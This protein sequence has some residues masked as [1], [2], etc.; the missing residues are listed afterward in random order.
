MYDHF[1]G[2]VV[3]TSGTRVVLRCGGVGYELKVPVGTATALRPGQ[4]ATLHT[5]LHVVDGSPSLI[6]FGSPAERDLA[7]RILAVSGVGPAIAL[8]ILSTYDPASFGRTILDGDV[9]ALKRVKGVGGKTA[10]RL[11]LE[12]R[13][14][15][16]QL[17]LPG[18]APTPA[19]DA[20]TP[21]ASDA[22]AALVTLGYVEKDASARV[23]KA[24]DADPD[25]GTEVLIRAVLRTG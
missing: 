13:D 9:A 3:E 12:L 23:A 24:L 11:C 4:Q 20:A 1:L 15:I 10:E 17:D 7:R 14:K 6:G 19:Q 2:E 16:A 21:A 22:I 25:A 5:I 18:A 8:G